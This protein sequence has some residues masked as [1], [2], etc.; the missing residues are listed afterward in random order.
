VVTHGYYAGK[1]QIYA[2]VINSGQT[3]LLHE[4]NSK[5]SSTLS[6]L[7]NSEYIYQL[8]IALYVISKRSVE[9]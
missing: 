9:M 4:L 5:R 7:S 3:V 1:R 8:R 6:L 2:M